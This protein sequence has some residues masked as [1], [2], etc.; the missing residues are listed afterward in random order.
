MEPEVVDLDRIKIPGEVK[1]AVEAIRMSGWSKPMNNFFKATNY[2][3]RYGEVDPHIDIWDNNITERNNY[4]GRDAIA[5]S[6]G[7]DS[8]TAAILSKITQGK[9]PILFKAE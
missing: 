1:D 9:P 2:I 4:T 6:G 7:K 5:F 8:V 3:S